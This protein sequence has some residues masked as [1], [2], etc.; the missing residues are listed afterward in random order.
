MVLYDA[1][2]GPLPVGSS[3]L[4]YTQRSGQNTRGLCLREHDVRLCSAVQGELRADDGRAVY[5]DARDEHGLKLW[6][7]SR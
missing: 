3:P 7:P 5:G 1:L 2:S 4:H 6:G